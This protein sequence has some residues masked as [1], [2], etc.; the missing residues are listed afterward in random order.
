MRFLRFFIIVFLSIG[1]FAC[2]EEDNNLSNDTIESIKQIS[3]D[4]LNGIAAFENINDDFYFS[5][6][7]KAIFDSMKRNYQD[8]IDN[9]KNWNNDDGELFFK[10]IENG[11]ESLQQIELLPRL[12]NDQTIPLLEWHGCIS[13]CVE[14]QVNCMKLCEPCDFSINN[15]CRFCSSDCIEWTCFDNCHGIIQ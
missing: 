4:G 15:P 3:N 11:F 5:E 10:E 9:S 1:F 14:R 8:A 6:S 2:E 12:D 7:D 13:V